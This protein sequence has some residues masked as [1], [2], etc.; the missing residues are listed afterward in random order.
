[1]SDPPYHRPVLLEESVQALALDPSGTYVDGTFGRGGHARAILARLGPA[2]RLVGID[3][4]PDAFAEARALAGADPRFIAVQARF[5][6]LTQALARAGVQHPVQGILLDLGVSSPQLDTPARGFGFTSDGPLDMRMDPA[7]GEPAHLWLA[8]ADRDDIVRVLREYGEER[9]AGRIA[10]AI[11]EARAAAPLN[12]TRQLAELV[13]RAVPKRE[14][15]KHPATRT[16]Q[17]LRI[18]V[19]DEL[20]E[21][22]RCLDQVCDLL[23]A[24]GR[25]V[26]I[27]FHSLEDRIVKRFMRRESRGPELP[28][29]VPVTADFTRGRLRILAKPVRPSPEEVAANPRSRSAILRVAERLA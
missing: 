11:L 21:I 14:P 23:A 5:G 28:K 15:G 20:G 12:T 1:M 27:S 6:D 4:D 26:A 18:Q 25:L 24:A 17:A 9:F 19:N 10:R 22:V 29:G 13:A 7:S 8:R 16:F 3:R 2:G